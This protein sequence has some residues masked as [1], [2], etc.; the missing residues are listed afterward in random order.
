MFFDWH[1]TKWRAAKTAANIP[2]TYREDSWTKDPCTRRTLQNK[3]PLTNGTD[4]SS[5]KSKS[6]LNSNLF[7]MRK[8]DM[9]RQVGDGKEDGCREA[10]G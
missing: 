6:T 7:F 3:T 5:S 1:Q 10:A 2:Q 9:L 8:N 4:D